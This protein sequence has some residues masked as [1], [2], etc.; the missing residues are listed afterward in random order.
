MKKLSTLIVLLL[1]ITVSANAENAPITTEP[2]AVSAESKVITDLFYCVKT[3]QRSI[4]K[5]SD[6][7]DDIYAGLNCDKVLEDLVK[8]EIP[9]EEI[10]NT[11]NKAIKEISIEDYIQCKKENYLSDKDLCESELLKAKKLGATDE[12]IKKEAG[13]LAV[14]MG[15]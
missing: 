7:F 8:L 12:E 10:S 14:L 9:E 3:S 15:L 11:I 2:A 1:G 13:E 5:S 6:V 4:E